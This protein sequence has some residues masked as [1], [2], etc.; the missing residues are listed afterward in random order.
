M[1]DIVPTPFSGAVPGVELQARMLISILE[2]NVPYTPIGKEI[3][4]FL[5]C[6][7]FALSLLIITRAGEKIA[8][9]AL[10]ISAIV[11]PC[12]ALWLHVVALGASNVWIGWV[13]AAVF[14]FIT[15][16]TLVLLEFTLV[17]MERAQVFSNLNSYLPDEIARA[18]AFALPSGKIEAE[19]KNVTLLSADLR[20]FSA[21]GEARPPEET[22][23][24]LHYFF[25]K[26]TELIESHGGHVQE[27]KGDSLIAMWDGAQGY[28][29]RLALSAARDLQASLND[30]LLPD[31]SLAGLEPLALGIGI[32][33]GP[34][35][36][37]SIGP[38]HRRSLTILGDTLSVTLRIQEMTADLSQP[39]LLGE[40]IA[41]Q[42]NGEKIESQGSF[43]LTGLRIPHTL[44]APNIEEV[45][46]SGT[47][48]KKQPELI[49]VGG[50]K[51]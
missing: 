16:A 30:T 35:L 24:V 27:F 17:R 50:G 45:A 39:I 5:L 2:M 4:S 49:V 8:A 42:L 36:I 7:A 28:E 31:Q 33:Q 9:V 1:G 20:N 26:A 13:N 43:L 14:G 48:G 21:F 38:A 12:L 15:A 34:V 29:A 46:S 18:I 3:L 6:L 11:L 32:E 47:S 10:P 37:G 44:F 19:R 41:R 25:T 22:A 51:R 40:C 23:A